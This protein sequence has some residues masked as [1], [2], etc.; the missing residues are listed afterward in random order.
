MTTIFHQLRR[1]PNDYALLQ[2][3]ADP[4]PVSSKTVPISAKHLL[5]VAEASIGGA[6]P[7]QLTWNL[8]QSLFL[9]TATF[10]NT[11]CD[12]DAIASHTQDLTIL[13]NS[14]CCTTA[15]DIDM[16]FSS[17]TASNLQ[18]FDWQL[19]TGGMTEGTSA[20]TLGRPS[21]RTKT[22]MGFARGGASWGIKEFIQRAVA[23]GHSVFTDNFYISYHVLPGGICMVTFVRRGSQA[24]A[25]FHA[26]IVRCA[27]T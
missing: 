19:Q 15:T 10:W 23:V 7:Q 5:V 12:F 25:A 1:G 9:T 27:Q 14:T 24:A 2:T 4:D 18:R 21:W 6:E 20:Q 3:L 8:P 17:I 22:P 11:T 26:N 13:G 16:L